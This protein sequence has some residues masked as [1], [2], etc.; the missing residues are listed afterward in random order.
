MVVM[1]ERRMSALSE[2]STTIKRKLP[3]KLP[4]CQAA[5]ARTQRKRG[6]G[7]DAD[8]GFRRAT[9]CVLFSGFRRVM[10]QHELAMAGRCQLV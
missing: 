6:V 2:R 3:T 9:A 1:P 7:F 5:E 8:G 4:S 10:S